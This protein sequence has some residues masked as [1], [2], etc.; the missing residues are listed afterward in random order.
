MKCRVQAQNVEVLNSSTADQVQR[1]RAVIECEAKCKRNFGGL[2]EGIWPKSGLCH[3]VVVSFT[4]RIISEGV[5]LVSC[6]NMQVHPEHCIFS[7][8]VPQPDY[9]PATEESWYR[10][11]SELDEEKCTDLCSAHM[12]KIYKACRSINAKDTKYN[13]ARTFS[14]DFN[15]WK[16][17]SNGQNLHRAIYMKKT[18]SRPRES[19]DLYSAHML[20]IYKACRSIKCKGHKVQPCQNLFRRLINGWKDVSNGK[21]L[22]KDIYM[23]KMMSRPRESKAH[24]TEEERK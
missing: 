19:T 2:N 1:T 6:E 4:R 24:T 22:H 8:L 9:E 15:G 11:R 23:K 13:Y 10:E 3:N 16:D 18:M 21:H 7:Y 12:L 20:K 5:A 14:E 17:V